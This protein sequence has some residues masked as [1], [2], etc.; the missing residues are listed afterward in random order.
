MYR[1]HFNSPFPRCNASSFASS[2]IHA[3]SLRP[4]FDTSS[5]RPW[6]VAMKYSPDSSFPSTPSTPSLNTV[7]QTHAFVSP[8][9]RTANSSALSNRPKN[10]SSVLTKPCA[11]PWVT[12]GSFNITPESRSA[13]APAAAP[14]SASVLF[15]LFCGISTSHTKCRFSTLPSHKTAMSFPPRSSPSIWRGQCKS[16]IR[17]SRNFNA[18]PLSACGSRWLF[19]RPVMFT[20]ASMMHVRSGVQSRR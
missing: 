5:S 14:S 6:I 19:T 11:I 12:L 17:C 3:A 10:S 1:N 7:R 18:T 20:I 4:A 16:P 13:H 9:H 8:A 15:V 2:L